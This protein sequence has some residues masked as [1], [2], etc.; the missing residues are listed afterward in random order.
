MYCTS[1]GKTFFKVQII[2]GGQEY[3]GLFETFVVL[4]APQAEIFTLETEQKCK[5]E[6]APFFYEF[7]LKISIN[8]KFNKSN[9][10]IV[11]RS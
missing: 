4:T 3:H 1:Y 6:I 9:Y 7:T 8:N 10:K 11:T 5:S 2:L